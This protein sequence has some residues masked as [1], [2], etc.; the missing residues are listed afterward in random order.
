MATIKVAFDSFKQSTAKDF[1]Q[2]PNKERDGSVVDWTIG[3]NQAV[4]EVAH[5]RAYFIP[6]PSYF[7]A[8]GA[9]DVF[10][11]REIYTVDNTYDPITGV[12][13]TSVRTREYTK[14][15]G[16][17]STG[18]TGSATDGW[19][20]MSLDS[21]TIVQDDDSGAIMVE[22]WSGLVSGVPNTLT[23][24]YEY[25]NPYTFDE[26]MGYVNDLWDAVESDFLA[27]GDS[28]FIGFHY[29]SGFSVVSGASFPN[30]SL[31]WPGKLDSGFGI[32][33]WMYFNSSGFQAVGKYGQRYKIFTSPSISAVFEL[34]KFERDYGSDPT[35]TPTDGSPTTVQPI[36][37]SD[38]EFFYPGDAFT[39]TFIVS[40]SIKARPPQ[41][42]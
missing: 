36:V 29:E 22:V 20:G 16:A 30:Y 37:D 21:R 8:R 12:P 27:M 2:S 11:C 24:T 25:E 4:C 1:I 42:P 18:T 14:D 17:Y 39:T 38:P 41:S 13:S 40:G 3:T 23:R 9:F 26:L 10:F 35:S 34:Q 28:D 15:D 5:F 6:N 7:A 32:A 33:G 31:N 19:S